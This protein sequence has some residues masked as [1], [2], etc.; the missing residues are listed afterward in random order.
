LVPALALWGGSYQIPNGPSTWQTTNPNEFNGLLTA[1]NNAEGLRIKPTIRLA[2][3]WNARQND[4]FDA[5]SFEKWII[6]QSFWLDLN[7]K[8]YLFRVFK[9]LNAHSSTEQWR[10]DRIARAKDIVS[11]VQRLESEG[12]PYSAEQEIKKLIPSD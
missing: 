12:M 9:N 8:D 6:E 2:K 11:N 1:K 3:F 4:V 5:F 7:L 10:R